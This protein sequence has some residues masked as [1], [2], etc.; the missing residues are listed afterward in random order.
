MKIE[1]RWINIIHK[2]WVMLNIKFTLIINNKHINTCLMTYVGVG[3]G[4]RL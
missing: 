3:L 4:C 2:Q 1:Q